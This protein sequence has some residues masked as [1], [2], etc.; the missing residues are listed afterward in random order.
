MQADGQTRSIYG[1]RGLSDSSYIGD[2]LNQN[3][4]IY[5]RSFDD[6][7][8]QYNQKLG[9]LGQFASG[10]KGAL[11]N[12][13]NNTQQYI[14]SLGQNIGDLSVADL[15]G[16][17]QTLGQQVNSAQSS[18]SNYMTNPQLLAELNKVTPINNAGTA[19]L[20]SRLQALV[21]SSAPIFA[22]R[23][24]AQGLVSASGLQDE[25]AKGYWQSEFEK[26]LKSAGQA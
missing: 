17:D 3:N 18:A 21:T 25:N 13:L 5:N 23:Q 20:A 1:A 19:Q 2:A 10:Q 12:Q 6:V 22:K 26:M 24:I 7:G 15:T 4:Q 9:Q 11:T 14:D 8:S 16:A